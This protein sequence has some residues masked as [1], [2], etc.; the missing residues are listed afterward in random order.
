MAE[1]ERGGEREAKVSAGDEDEILRFYP[2]LK[3]P[4]TFYSM[5]IIGDRNRI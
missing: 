1:R 5:I 2:S 3:Y 4:S